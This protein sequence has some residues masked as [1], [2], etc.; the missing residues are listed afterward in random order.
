MTLLA[1]VFVFARLFVPLFKTL[2]FLKRQVK[3]PRKE[4]VEDKTL[5]L[6]P[7]IL[8]EC[9]GEVQWLGNKDRGHNPSKPCQRTDRNLNLIVVELYMGQP[10]IFSN[11]CVWM[12]IFLY[13]FCSQLLAIVCAPQINSYFRLLPYSLEVTADSS[14]YL[15]WQIFTWDVSSRNPRVMCFHLGLNQGSLTC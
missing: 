6:C 14:A 3:L 8:D 10:D 9:Q 15:T 7:L 13:S 2:M 11:L 12:C 5:L 4:A 1:Y